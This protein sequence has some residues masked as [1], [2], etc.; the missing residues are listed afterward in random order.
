MSTAVATAEPVTAGGSPFTGTWHVARHIL[1]RD[2]VRMLVWIGSVVLFVVYFMW[3]LS[4]V[5]DEKSM[6]ARGEIMR[7]PSGIVMGGP[8][9]GLDHYTAPVA[10]ANEGIL[11]SVLA[12]AVLSI[13]HVVRH[14]RAEE[15]SGRSELVRA[16]A[17]GALAVPAAALGTLAA[18]L[19]AIAVLS[20]LAMAAVGEDVPVADAVAMMLGSALSAF[21]FGAAA[22]VLCQVT[23]HARAATG[24]SLAVFGAAFVIRAAGDI[25]ETGGSALSWFSPIAWAQQMRPFVDLRWW[26]AAL[27]I[28]TAVALLGVAAALARRRDFD[29]GLIAE[30]RGREHARPG[31]RGPFAVALRQQRGPIFW[32]ALGLG[33]MWFGSGTMMS[34]MN[35]LVSELVE[36]N[37]L[38]GQ[39][40]GTD[41]AAF[42]ESF[43]DVM[44]MFAALCAAA[45][46]VSAAQHPRGE[47]VSGRLEIVAATPVTRARWLGAQ[48]S[49]AVIGALVVLIVSILALW[50]GAAAVGVTEPGFGA[51]ARVAV[52][53][54]AAILAVVALAAALY[55]WAPRLMGLAWLPIGAIFVL[56]MF[57]RMLDLPD[58]V[59]R[60][61]PFHWAAS[62][63]SDGLE[64]AAAVAL[65]VAAVVLAAFGLAGFRRRD[66]T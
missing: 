8:G 33:L 41:P 64:P 5:F 45:Y 31:L 54:A 43:L 44:A 21:V 16:S 49:A 2:R 12:L 29:A 22:L 63:F 55:G 3:A 25:A 4:T 13:V 6:A 9:Y 35:D 66:V 62:T 17:V 39:L 24:M 28:A 19:T 50:A 51:Y 10:V 65:F 59:L 7:T 53:Y 52:A 30:R 46:G 11:W 15:E 18:L 61:S 58:W 37:P 32:T 47:E 57:G 1:R 27:S 60:L 48:L 20:A 23:A 14:T 34:T 56:Q 38:I 26:P 42:T 40:F 36:T